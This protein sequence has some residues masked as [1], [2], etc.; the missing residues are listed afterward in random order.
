MIKYIFINVW[1]LQICTK[2]FLKVHIDS[3]IHPNSKFI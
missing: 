3:K 2:F 1:S